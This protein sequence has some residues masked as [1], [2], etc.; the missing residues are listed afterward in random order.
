MI[1]PTDQV[2][3]DR[4]EKILEAAGEVFFECGY[5]GACIDRIIDKVG[6]SK[7]TIY[8]EFGN[9]EGLFGA[10]LKENVQR[11][12]Q[13][14]SPGELGGHDLRSTLTS[15]GRRTMGLQMSARGTALYRVVVSEG[16][17][18][19]ELAKVFWDNGP[20]LIRVKLAEAL[21][22]YRRRGELCI[23]D[24]QAA[25]DLFL[26]MIR[27]TRHLAIVLGLREPPDEAERESMLREIVEVFLAG[28]TKSALKPAGGC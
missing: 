22:E 3:Q 7:R 5:A 20:G 19:P 4:R 6:G 12:L 9:K 13:D 28:I 23:K 14:L 16:L 18:F 17:R 15:F 8:E 26:G 11:T 2:R 25:A 24:S 1:K 10:L 27:N 21:E